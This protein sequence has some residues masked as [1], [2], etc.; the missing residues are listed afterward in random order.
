MTK[1]EIDYI[2]KAF[3]L[4]SKRAQDAGFDGVETNELA[5]FGPELIL[6]KHYGGAQTGLPYF[7]IEFA[8][9]PAA[10]GNQC[11]LSVYYP[12]TPGGS[13]RYELVSDDC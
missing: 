1:D 8:D 9:S 13:V 5:G 6:R 2:V 12:D 10:A 3:A 7:V 11:F 4:A